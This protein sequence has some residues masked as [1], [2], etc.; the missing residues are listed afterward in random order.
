MI[1]DTPLLVSDSRRVPR[2]FFWEASDELLLRDLWEP[3]PTSTA[4]PWTDTAC[5]DVDSVLMFKLDDCSSEWD[6]IETQRQTLAVTHRGAFAANREKHS[7][8][9][10][11]ET[12]SANEMIDSRWYNDDWIQIQPQM[13]TIS[14]STDT[15]VTAAQSCSQT[16]CENREWIRSRML[17]M[18]VNESP[19]SSDT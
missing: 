17:Q 2:D 11:S 9:Q 15:A 18:K 7:M 4:P 14:G 8:I 6:M 3:V 13:F 12:S 16:V 5:M 19:K 1:D 10:S